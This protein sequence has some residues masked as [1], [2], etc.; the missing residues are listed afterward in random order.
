M[1][2]IFSF[3]VYDRDGFWGRIQ[4]YGASLEDAASEAMDYV[5]D[6]HTFPLG[7][8]E[9]AFTLVYNGA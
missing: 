5:R 6:N 2:R 3:A 8:V 9:G 4:A 1:T 7:C